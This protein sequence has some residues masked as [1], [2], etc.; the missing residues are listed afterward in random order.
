MAVR[1]G[2]F[3]Q[4]HPEDPFPV[5]VR[6]DNK[7]KE[8]LETEEQLG[9]RFRTGRDGDYLMGILFKC[10]LCYFRNTNGRDH[11]PENAKDNFTLLAICRGSL[12]ATWGRETSTVSGN[13]RRLQ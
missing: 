6:L 11:I 10:D 7:E 13:F 2:K 5:Q 1:C 3:N 4:A 9:Q 8:D 12:D